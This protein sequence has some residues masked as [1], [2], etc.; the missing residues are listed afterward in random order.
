MGRKMNG[1]LNSVFVLRS[2]ID[3]PGIRLSYFEVC[4]NA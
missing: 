4:L 2:N 3:M 1:R